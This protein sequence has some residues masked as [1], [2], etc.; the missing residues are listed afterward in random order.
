[1]LCFCES[2]FIVSWFQTFQIN[3][4]IGINLNC[5]ITNSAS[6]GIKPFIKQKN[7]A[8]APGTRR[9]HY[10]TLYHIIYL[11]ITCFFCFVVFSQKFYMHFSG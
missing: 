2:Y 5:F 8:T 1:M 4:K 9:N 10:F 7:Q 3:L 6:G 11:F